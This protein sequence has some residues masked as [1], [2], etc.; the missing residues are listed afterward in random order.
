[1]AVSSSNSAAITATP[2]SNAVAGNYAIEVT[3]TAQSQT[4]TSG[5]FGGT[6]TFANGGKLT[7]S[8]GVSGASAIPI[9]IPAGSNLSQVAA[10][11]NKANAGVSATILNDGT[12]QRLVL[13]STQTGTV[14]QFSITG[15]G[16]MGALSY[17]TNDASLVGSKTGEADSAGVFKAAVDA[18]AVVNGVAITSSSNIF[19]NVIQGLTFTAVTAGSSTLTVSTDTETLQKQVTE[20]VTAYNALNNLLTTST[21]YEE[22]SKT[23]GIFQGDSSIVNLQNALRRTFA[24]SVST[25]PVFQ[26]LTD[27][28]IDIKTGGTMSINETKLKEGL[29]KMRQK[30]QNSLQKEVTALPTKCCLSPNL[31]KTPAVFWIQSQMPY[32]KLLNAI[33]QSKTKSM[34]ERL[35]L[36]P[37]CARNIQPWTPKCLLLTP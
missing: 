3:S 35:Q 6:Q 12:G 4:I 5:R 28:G 26:R 16:D 31:F 20:F 25:S 21:K 7:I 29:Q 37:V 30:W 23:A 13:S 34:T 17:N 33:L 14:H 36:K 22:S 10:A 15:E 2:G 24:E 11:I 1:M 18:K 27:I 8:T 32:P 9:D 19:D